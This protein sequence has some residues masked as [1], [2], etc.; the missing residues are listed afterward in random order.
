M[1][2]VWRIFG[3]K[4]GGQESYWG[5]TIIVQA[6]DHKGLNQGNRVGVQ[7]DDQIQELLRKLKLQDLVDWK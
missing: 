7:R 2:A 5:A 6:R 1:A 4:P 3:D